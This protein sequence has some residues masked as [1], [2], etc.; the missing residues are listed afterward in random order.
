MSC[1][2]RHRLI[3]HGM[4]A[5]FLLGATDDACGRSPLQDRR[6]CSRNVSL[7]ERRQVIRRRTCAW[8]CGHHALVEVVLQATGKQTK[9][10]MG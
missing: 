10:T 8:P 4:A 6:P 7:V 1:A 3:V 2:L 5:S 9:V